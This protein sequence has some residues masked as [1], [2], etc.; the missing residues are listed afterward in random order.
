MV[1]TFARQLL[2]SPRTQNESFRNVQLSFVTAAALFEEQLHSLVEDLFFGLLVVV[3][4]VAAFVT[5]R[6]LPKVKP[7]VA[8]RP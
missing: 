8:H 7:F 4:S 1:C 6:R 3:L 2:A 5:S